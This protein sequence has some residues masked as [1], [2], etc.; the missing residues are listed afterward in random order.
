MC[1]MKGYNLCLASKPTIAGS[2]GTEKDLG[3]AKKEKEI[4]ETATKGKKKNL[5]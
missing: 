1:A 2:Q 5:C 3:P 4:K